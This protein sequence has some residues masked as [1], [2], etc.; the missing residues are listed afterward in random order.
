MKNRIKILNVWIDPIDEEESI[1]IVEG[2]LDKGEKLHTVFAINPEKNFSAPSD[3]LLY[4]TIKRA[5][6]LLPDGIGMVIA[7]RILYGIKISRVAGFETMNN[8]CRL[9]SRKG[10]GIFLYGAK[11]DVNS[12]TA[13]KLP[14]MYPG[15]NISGRSSGFV[16]EED[17]LNLISQIN[18][19]G[20][21]ILFLALGSPRQEK[22]LSAHRELLKNIKVCQ[23]V[24]G[25]FDVIAGKVKRSP[26]I[27][28]KYNVEWL[29]RLLAEPKRIKRQKM[30][31]V[32]AFLVVIE[33]CKQLMGRKKK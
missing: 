22:W 6:L 9:A 17:M 1:K 30:L 4:E 10:T 12:I 15:L 7:A 26:D 3:P 31:P 21:E 27:W 28:I 32:F 33:K 23:G 16:R 24:G 25:S 11:E 20:A 14:E 2:F 5:D 19:S 18:D 29:Y 13:E 8:I